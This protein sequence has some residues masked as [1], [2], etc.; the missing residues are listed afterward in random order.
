MEQQITEKGQTI[1]PCGA[2]TTEIHEHWCHE[3]ASLRKEVVR[4]RAD[5]KSLRE[6]IKGLLLEPFEQ[7]LRLYPAPKP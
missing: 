1:Q 2:T 3:V 4:L 6:A 5:G 7:H